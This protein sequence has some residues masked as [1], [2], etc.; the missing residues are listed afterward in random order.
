VVLAVMA[1]ALFGVGLRTAETQTTPTYY[2]VEDLGTLPEDTSSTPHSIA[3]GINDHGPV[4]GESSLSGSLAG[5][6][7]VHAFLYENGQM[8][9][10]GTLPGATSSSAQDINKSGQV[11]GSTY[12]SFFLY[13]NEEMIDLGTRLLPDGN[14]NDWRLLSAAAINN[15][16]H[17]VSEGL[18]QNGD[19]YRQCWQWWGDDARCAT[20]GS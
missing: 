18:R 17:I 2:K 12:G 7:S 10:L 8:K 14:G 9:D 11:V 16:G 15:E 3:Q 1:V 13:Q 20:R 4:V 6:G 5:D 19:F